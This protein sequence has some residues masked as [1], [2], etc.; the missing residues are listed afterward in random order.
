MIIDMGPMGGGAM[1]FSYTGQYRFS[2]DAKGDWTIECLS[3]G[4]L[5]FSRLGKAGRGV[6]LF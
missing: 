6:D 4:T 3:S 2:G 1:E 5:R